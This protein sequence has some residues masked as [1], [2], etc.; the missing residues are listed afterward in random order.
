MTPAHAG[1]TSTD[2]RS[3]WVVLI[4]FYALTLAISWGWTLP[5]VLAGSGVDRGSGW[6]THMP[7]LLGPMIAAVVVTAWT[8]GVSG[9][10]DLGGRMVRWRVGLRW[11]F[12]GL[13][14]PLAYFAA[15]AW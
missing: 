15:G 5:F 7:A 8:Q 9:V 14:S 10:R 3:I 4:G 2:I 11:W 12:R 13:A 6:P 1:S